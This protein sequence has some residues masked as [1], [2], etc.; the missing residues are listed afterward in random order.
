MN[1]LCGTASVPILYFAVSFSNQLF[2]ALMSN[3]FRELTGVRFPAMKAEARRNVSRSFSTA[4][5][6]AS[7][8]S[9]M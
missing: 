1:R 4:S 5:A 8:L 9:R 7:S 3:A 2:H 6:A